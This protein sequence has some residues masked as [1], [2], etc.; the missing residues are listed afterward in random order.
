[1]LPPF[2]RTYSRKNCEM[3]CES[4]ILIE[5]CGCVLYYMPRIDENTNIC[6]RDDYTCYNQIKLAI[7]LAVNETFKC[8]CLPGCFEINYSA[9]ISTARLG[10]EGFAVQQNIIRRA[11]S[12]Y[13]Q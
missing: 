12:E 10:T 2:H 4:R 13:V 9:D 1:M 5:M 6:S 8:N 7:E 3:E 11:K